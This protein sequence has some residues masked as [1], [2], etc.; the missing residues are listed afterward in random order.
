MPGLQSK[1]SPGPCSLGE[2]LPQ[3]RWAGLSRTVVKVVHCIR[4]HLRKLSGHM[5]DSST[6][7]S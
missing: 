7:L 2:F 6:C 5:V 3:S 1:L 4:T